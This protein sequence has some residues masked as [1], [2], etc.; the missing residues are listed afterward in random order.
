MTAEYL[1]DEIRFYF[2]R[3]SPSFAEVFAENESP[4]DGLKTKPESL[5]AMFLLININRI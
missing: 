3:F 2:I 1:I 4:V 5:R